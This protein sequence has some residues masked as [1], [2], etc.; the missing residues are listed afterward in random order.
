MDILKPFKEYANFKD[1]A[2]RKEFWTFFIIVFAVSFIFKAINVLSLSLIWSLFVFIPFLAV[3]V[4]RLHDINFSGWWVL[5]NLIPFIGWVILLY[6]FLSKG[7]K[8]L[9]K[10]GSLD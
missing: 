9:N 10:Y 8:G 1:R 3:S 6:F 4:R 7:S 5:L 2:N